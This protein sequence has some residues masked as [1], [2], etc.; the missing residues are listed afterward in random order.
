MEDP[1]ATSFSKTV[2]S[3]A[4]AIHGDQEGVLAIPETLT[5][6]Q[7]RSVAADLDVPAHYVDQALT[8]PIVYK[9][10]GKNDYQLMVERFIPGDVAQVDLE[11]RTFLL[12]EKDM[13]VLSPIAN[14]TVFALTA[15]G[16]SSASTKRIPHVDEVTLTY[17]PLGKEGTLVRMS[18]QFR[19]IW[20]D[21]IPSGIGFGF[22]GLV[23]P[24]LFLDL[25]GNNVHTIRLAFFLAWFIAALI[26]AYISY[27]QW[28]DSADSATLHFTGTLAAIADRCCDQ[29]TVTQASLGP[30]LAE[31]AG[32]FLGRFISSF[33]RSSRNP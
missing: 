12:E 33:R 10:N 29:Q 18:G 28:K 22:L 30:D 24:G 7:M 16:K 21:A 32:G 9:P 31:Q 25:L 15:L 6:D 23:I 3:R 20:S 14:G 4:L 27:C 1:E 5:I 17:T 8:Q 26:G 13:M 11:A 19:R 2:L